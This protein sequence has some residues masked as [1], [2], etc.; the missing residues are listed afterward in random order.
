MKKSPLTSTRWLA[1]LALLAFG[2]GAANPAQ[3]T[4][5][6]MHSGG[7]WSV[8]TSWLNTTVPN[9]A[10]DSAQIGDSTTKLTATNDLAVTLGNLTLATTSANAAN[11]LSKGGTSTLTMNNSG[12][13]AVIYKKSADTLDTISVGLVLQDNLQ[14]YTGSS[15]GYGLA[16]DASGATKGITADA[17]NRTI[18]V[19]PIP[20]LGHQNLILISCVIGDG[21]AGGTISIA[22]NTNSVNAGTNQ[23][24]LSGANTFSGSTSNNMGAWLVLSNSLA[25]QNS[26]LT[27]NGGILTFGGSATAYTIGGLASGAAGAGYDLGLTNN[28]PTPAAVTL[29]I[30]KNNSSP[31]YAGVIGGSGS[32]IKIGTGTQTLSAACTYTGSTTVSNGSLTLTGAGSIASSQL[33][34]VYSNATLTLASALS[35]GSGQTLQGGGV[36]AGGLVTLGSGATLAAY[37]AATAIA[38]LT[39]NSLTL[40]AGCTNNFAFSPVTNDLVNVTTSGGLTLNGGGFNLYKTNS[41]LPLTTLGTYNLFQYAGSVSGL[42]S[43]WTTAS[44][45]NPHILN[46]QPGLIYSFAAVGGYV[47]LTITSTGSYWN[48]ST[49]GSWNTG[50]DWTPANVPSGAGAIVNF[51]NGGTA[52]TAPST[53]TLDANQTV[54]SLYFNSPQSFTIISGSPGNSTIT[55]DNSPGNPLINDQTGNHTNNAP[56]ALNQS[57]NIIEVAGASL[58]L[59]GA[60]SDGSHGGT[61][62]TNSGGGT[63]TLGGANTYSGGTVLSGSTVNLNNAAALGTGPLTINAGVILDNSSG[64]SLT[65]LNNNAQSWNNNFTFLGTTNLDL[66]AGAV[67]LSA[68]RTVTVSSNNLTVE[69]VISGPTF[70]LTK[71][72]AGQLTLAGNSAV[73]NVT[74]SAGT[75]SLNAAAGALPSAGT[76]NLNGG[77]LDVAQADTINTF[78]LAASSTASGAGTLTVSTLI[79]PNIA[80]TNINNISVALAGSAQFKKQG[81]GQTVLSGANSYTGGTWINGSAGNKL[82]I[83]SPGTLGGTSGA[84]NLDTTGDILDL[85]ATTQTVGAVTVSGILTNGTLNGASFVVTNGFASANLGGGSAPLTKVGTGTFVLSG[86]NTYTGATTVSAGTLQVDGSTAGGSAVAVNGGTLSGTGTVG[87]SVTVASGAS[88]TPGDNNVGTLTVNGNL[89]LNGGGLLTIAATNTGNYSKV[90]VQGNLNPSGVTTVILP[91]TP[92]P[93]G[94]YPLLGVYGTLG[95]SAANFSAVSVSPRNYSIVYQSGSPNTVVLQVTTPVLLT[96]IG[97]GFSDNW[98]TTDSGDWVNPYPTP[99]TYADPSLDSVVFDDTAVPANT[100]VN[101]AGTVSPLAVTVS[102]NTNSY[103]ITRNRAPTA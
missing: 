37:N 85:G 89:T 66:G 91:A 33:I 49:G 25:L 95:G 15:G 10:G 27:M 76:V 100:T 71:A 65:N 1:S 73:T 19:G 62:L 28:A 72:G 46:P 48:L 68:S 69:G 45:S 94:N 4:S 13:G 42:D 50:A 11:V 26:T 81:V 61:S 64:A 22:N 52:I 97:D 12:A 93:N 5:S 88:L 38:T 90:I 58:A 75:L 63:L 54:G 41:T 78:N 53:V 79:N 55:L 102:N 57:V 74:I 96:W 2:F 83:I 20:T 36:V 34:N 21:S 87:G 30:G 16:I 86:A 23:L 56:L 9:A 60:I 31:S 18:S 3:A 44:A 6:I 29:T 40:N 51:G 101:L 92:L 7:Y 35:L 84:L 43:T 32:L 67:T 80:T 8:S 14:I 82:A 47:Q 59:A 24:I 17:N 39:L 103:A 77:T 70:T 98:N 99:A